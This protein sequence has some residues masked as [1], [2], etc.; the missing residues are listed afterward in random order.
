VRTFRPGD[1]IV[2]FGLAGR[3]KV[4]DLFI[5]ARIPLADRRSIPL[6]FSA[7]RLIWVCGVRVAD[8]ARVV[9]GTQNIIRAEILGQPRN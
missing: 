7:G 3:K 4:K 9:A 6:V 8:G 1:R 5:D 2:P